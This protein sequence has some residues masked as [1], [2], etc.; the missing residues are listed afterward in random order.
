MA[1]LS[2][3]TQY[4]YKAAVI[5]DTE[6]FYGEVRTFTTLPYTQQLPNP[7]NHKSHFSFSV[8]SSSSQDGMINPNGEV[9]KVQEI[10]I[11]AGRTGVVVFAHSGPKALDVND[12]SHAL[13]VGTV[14]SPT[15]VF[16]KLE[17]MSINNQNITLKVSVNGKTV[18]LPGVILPEPTYTPFRQDVCR[19][20]E[21]EE[22]F[23]TVK[24]ISTAAGYS[25]RFTGCKLD[26]I[27]T[28]LVDK[29]VKIKTLSSEY[30]V[31]K[32]MISPSGKFAIFFS[33]KDPYYGDYTLKGTDFTYKFNYYEKDEDNPLI[34]GE[35]SGK[36]WVANGYGR[37][38]VNSDL[39]DNSGKS[40]SINIIFKMTT[41][42]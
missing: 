31:S 5:I 4:W 27:S 14:F 25:Q 24:E 41:E 16:S 29:G 9:D 39:K 34:A 20:W 30:N 6:T 35:A 1:G 40:Y 17:V 19:N 42:K 38:E 2:P 28:D 11:P 36:L 21:I 13:T 23:I 3:E 33:G 7:A 8:N 15:S 18:T 12:V 22:T 32:I 10:T 37:L 26:V